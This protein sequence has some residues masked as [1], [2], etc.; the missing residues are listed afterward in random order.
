MR[1]R[2]AEAERAA[3]AGTIASCAGD[4]ASCTCANDPIGVEQR[5]EQVSA[6]LYSTVE[7]ASL[8][9]AAQHAS[10]GCKIRA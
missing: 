8:P 9:E 3:E 5:F 6:S 1:E 10:L 7:L 4:A 2:Y